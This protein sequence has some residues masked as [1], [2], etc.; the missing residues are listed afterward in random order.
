MRLGTTKSAA[1]RRLRVA[2]AASG[3]VRRWR[4]SRYMLTASFSASA[5]SGTLAVLYAYPPPGALLA[6]VS[7]PCAGATLDRNFTADLHASAC[8][9]AAPCCVRLCRLASCWQ[10]KQAL[11]SACRGV[12][13]P[14]VVA[15]RLWRW[16]QLEYPKAQ[17]PLAGANRP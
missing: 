4:S 7:R 6:V 12:S 2:R 5:S 13:Q 11:C 8:R 1:P 3:A 17:H 16:R 10:S 9:S 14:L 15:K